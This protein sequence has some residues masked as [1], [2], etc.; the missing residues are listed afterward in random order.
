MLIIRPG[1]L[2]FSGTGSYTR[3]DIFRTY[4]CIMDYLYLLDEMTSV[5]GAVAIVDLGN[6]TVKQYMAITK[7][8]KADFLQTWQSGYPAR[9]KKIHVYNIGALADVILNLIKFCMTEKIQQRVRTHGQAPESLYREV[10]MH[11][12]PKEYLP[13]AYEG[14]HVGTESEI[15]EILKSEIT[16]PEIRDRLRY[17]SSDQF[18]MEDPKEE[19]EENIFVSAFRKLNFD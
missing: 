11:L 6:F 15:I 7:E 19:H 1:N 5:N 13:S 9:I 3:Q 8:E 4:A 12:L 18:G 2:D 17:I 14:S 10:P 16:K